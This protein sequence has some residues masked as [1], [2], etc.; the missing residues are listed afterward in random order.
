[1]LCSAYTEL[2]QARFLQAWQAT[3]AN[4]VAACPYYTTWYFLK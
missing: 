1:L 2:C 4:M 3:W